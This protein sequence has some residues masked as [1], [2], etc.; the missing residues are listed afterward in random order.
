MNPVFI[1]CS[2]GF[3]LLASGY[4][5]LK[6]RTQFL[7]YFLVIL[8]SS[9]QIIGALMKVMHLPG[10]DQILMVGILSTLFGAILLMITSIKN[11]SNE[12]Q[13]NKLILGLLILGQ[14]LIPVMLPEHTDVA[15]LFNYPVTALC[16]TLLINKQ[17][18]HRGEK[19]MLIL[20]LLFGCFYIIFELIKRF[21]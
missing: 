8:F 10:A 19:N 12:L 7:L 20:F 13:S 3:L 21:Q 18:E 4:L 11:T 15:S 16:G 2:S 17:S 1:F 14:I 6:T 9:A 5:L